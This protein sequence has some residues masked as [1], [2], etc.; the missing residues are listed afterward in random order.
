MEWLRVLIQKLLRYSLNISVELSQ[1]FLYSSFFVSYKI[2]LAQ[3]PSFMWLEHK[4][5]QVLPAEGLNTVCVLN[6]I[7]VCARNS[8]CCIHDCL[9]YIYQRF[10]N[11]CSMICIW[12]VIPDL[13]LK[14]QLSNLSSWPNTSHCGGTCI[15]RRGSGMTSLDC[16]L[17]KRTLGW[18]TRMEAK[19]LWA[20]YDAYAIPDSFSCTLYSLRL[21]TFQAMAHNNKIPRI[22]YPICRPRYLLRRRSLL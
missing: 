10:P 13:S 4:Y 11:T 8:C 5:D 16:F 20:L 3:K 22:L 15:D 2:C 7:A 21:L 6:F 18:G 17:R 9:Y 14:G 12:L 1:I 19:S